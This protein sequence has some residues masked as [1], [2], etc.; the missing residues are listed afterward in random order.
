MCGF[1][2][3]DEP[4]DGAKHYILLVGFNNAHLLSY[5]AEAGVN[6]NCIIRVSSQD[7]SRFA[8]P[9]QEST[10][11]EKDE[12]AQGKLTCQSVYYG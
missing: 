4:D 10:M 3:D 7:Y 12:K 2:P 8:P 5:L 11:A 6:V 9:P 1:V